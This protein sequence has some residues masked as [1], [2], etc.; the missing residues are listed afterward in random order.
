MHGRSR[1]AMGLV[2]VDKILLNKVKDK[3]N[4]TVLLDLS[5]DFNTVPKPLMKLNDLV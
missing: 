3:L 4:E 5:K 2:L 1:T